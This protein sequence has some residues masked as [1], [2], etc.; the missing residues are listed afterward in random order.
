MKTMMNSWRWFIYFMTTIE[1]IMEAP[2]RMPK[3]PKCSYRAGSK[4]MLAAHMRTQHAKGSL[5]PR[6]RLRTARTRRNNARGFANSLK[7]PSALW[8]L[9]TDVL[10][11][12]GQSLT[13][14]RGTL[15]QQVK[16]AGDNVRNLLR[17]MTGTRRNRS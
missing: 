9:P 12:I 10:R 16:A 3:C 1:V 4:E 8:K 14:K 6:T 2:N 5:S 15:K 17:N 11:S 7:S 13:G